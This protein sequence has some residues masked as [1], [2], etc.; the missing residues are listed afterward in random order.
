[1]LKFDADCR[2]YDSRLATEYRK[3]LKNMSEHKLSEQGNVP[4]QTWAERAYC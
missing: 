1:M 2:E 3:R 4:R